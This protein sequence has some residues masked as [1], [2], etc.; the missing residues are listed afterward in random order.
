MCVFYKNTIGARTR[1]EKANEGVARVLY[2]ALDN[3]S[4]LD[5]GSNCM[6]KTPLILDSVTS[7]LNRQQIRPTPT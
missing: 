4:P 1:K 6:F 2:P 7:N 5:K 3:L